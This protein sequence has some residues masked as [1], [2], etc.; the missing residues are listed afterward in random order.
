V[1]KEG[2]VEEA[3]HAFDFQQVVTSQ[4]PSLS[5]LFHREKKKKIFH[6]CCV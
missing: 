4:P 2:R 3:L 6:T 5:M 1:E